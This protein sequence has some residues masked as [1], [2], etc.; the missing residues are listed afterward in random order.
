MTMKEAGLPEWMKKGR[1]VTDT[2]IGDE[3]V[4]TFIPTTFV[5]KNLARLGAFMREV[6]RMG[7]S[8][9]L[10]G[11]GLL[12]AVSTSSRMAG[13]FILIVAGSVTGGAVALLILLGIMITLALAS[14][15]PLSGIFRK[16]RTPAIFTFIVALP[17]LF[18]VPGSATLELGLWGLNITGEG[19]RSFT[20]LLFRVVVMVS[21]LSLLSLTTKEAELIQGLRALGLPS[22]FVT[23]LFVTFRY[24]FVLIKLVEDM[25]LSRK[26]RVIRS[27]NATRLTSRKSERA[28]FGAGAAYLLERSVKTADD[29]CLAMTSR[30]FRGNFDRKNGEGTAIITSA[31]DALWLLFCIFIFIL[32]MGS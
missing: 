26:S 12:Y 30:G 23:A 29:V 16:V 11:N 21:F 1:S 13:I 17:A 14:R 6:F 9:V 8:G 7:H 31:K 15:V 24:V 4:R 5:D 20:T 2:T 27:V 22:F 19:V 10:S 18:M 25:L 32:V 3:V 28:W